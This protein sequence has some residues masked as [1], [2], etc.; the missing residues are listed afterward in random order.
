MLGLPTQQD[1]SK[2]VHCSEI[3]EQTSESG[4]FEIVGY[5]KNSGESYYI[6][7]SPYAFVHSLWVFFYCCRKDTGD[8]KVVERSE[9]LPPLIKSSTSSTKAKFNEKWAG[10]YG[11]MLWSV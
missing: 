9:T 3:N 6:F 4:G 8:R 11:Y 10:G 2:K 1:E 5:V 7:H